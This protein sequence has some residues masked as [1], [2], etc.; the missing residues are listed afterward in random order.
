MASV[1]VPGAVSG[2]TLGI[3]DKQSITA[4]LPSADPGVVTWQIPPRIGTITLQVYVTSAGSYYAEVTASPIADVVAGTADWFDL[5]GANQS[6]SRQQA[7]FSSVTAV[8]VTRV[9]GEFR[10]CIRGQ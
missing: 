10:A 1:V 3:S 8:R 4:A 9:S 2:G 5:F 7:I 6:A